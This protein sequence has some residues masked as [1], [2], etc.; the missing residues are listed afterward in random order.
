[1]W[2]DVAVK[3]GQCNHR[4]VKIFIEEADSAEH[5]AVGSTADPLGCEKTVAFTFQRHGCFLRHSKAVSKRGPL[6]ETAS[7]HLQTKSVAR[8]LFPF[9]LFSAH[10]PATNKFLLAGACLATGMG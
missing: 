3:G 9:L 5:S 1:A 2:G 8:S 7:Q 10:H 4:P 6:F